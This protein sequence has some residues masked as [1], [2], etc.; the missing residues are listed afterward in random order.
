MSPGTCEDISAMVRSGFYVKHDLMPIFCEEMYEPGELDPEEVSAV[1]DREF[2]KLAI[3]QRSWPAV[4]DCDRLDEAFLAINSRGVIALQN[5]G[6]TQSD[7]YDDFVE[8]LK[9]MPDRNTILGYCFYHGQDLDRAVRGGGLYLAFG[10]TD[11]RDEETKGP[12]V[13]R[14]IQDELLRVGL[15]VEWDGGFGTRI[16]VPRLTWQRRIA[17]Q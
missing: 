7:G 1:L 3:A 10:P 14:I 17:A 12:G 16:F 9:E 15:P 5:A 6:Y 4:T 13:G 2:Q 8:S 11:P